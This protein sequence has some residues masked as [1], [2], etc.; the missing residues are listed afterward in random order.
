MFTSFF[1]YNLGQISE[2]APTYVAGFRLKSPR[3]VRQ[4]PKNKAMAVLDEIQIIQLHLVVF[5]DIWLS[6]KNFN[7]I[8]REKAFTS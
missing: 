8:R 7:I 6:C 3:T 4:R 1:N 5:M 2:Q